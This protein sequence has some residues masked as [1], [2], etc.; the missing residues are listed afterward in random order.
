MQARLL[1]H[2]GRVMRSLSSIIKNYRTLQGNII[3]IGKEETYFQAETN[4]SSAAIAVEESV[5]QINLAFLEEEA[6]KE[7]MRIVEEAELQAKAMLEQAQVEIATMKQNIE[8]ETTAYRKQIAEELNMKQVKAQEEVDQIVKVA[9]LEKESIIKQ[10]EPEIVELIG[11]LIHK[12]VDFK[13]ISGIEWLT[14]FVKQAIEKEQFRE[15]IQ[16]IIAPEMLEENKQA[17]EEAFKQLPID[18]ELTCDSRL[19]CTTCKVE[20]PT[21]GITYDIK[22]GLQKMLDELQL[23]CME[24]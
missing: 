12:I 6:K 24:G 8:A 5:E 13:L 23:L 19:S 22:E 9:Y 18:V 1:F 21:G 10:A 4:S 17:L 20:T 16:V 11:V 15:S 14:L 3:S 7:A 2:V